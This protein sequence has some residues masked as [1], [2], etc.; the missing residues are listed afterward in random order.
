MNKDKK[1]KFTKIFLDAYD[2]NLIKIV[3]NT[4]GFSLAIDSKSKNLIPELK[5]KEFIDYIFSI[6][7]IVIDM[8][9]NDNVEDVCEA[10]LKVAKMIYIRE[11]DLKN[12]LYIKRNSKINCFKLME[13]QIISYRSEENPK[14]IEANAAILKMVT[15]KDD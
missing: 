10:D 14:D 7:K 4:S 5:D 11:K 2:N 6:V 12:H 8:A 9:E 3:W 15:E 1:E 13:S